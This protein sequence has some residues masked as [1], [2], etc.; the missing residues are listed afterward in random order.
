MLAIMNFYV[1]SLD[2]KVTFHENFFHEQ[3]YM[4]EIDK[5]ECVLNFPDLIHLKVPIIFIKGNFC[6][7]YSSSCNYE[8]LIT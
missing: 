2:E 3:R 1:Y 5:T 7:N 6:N 4:R 8:G